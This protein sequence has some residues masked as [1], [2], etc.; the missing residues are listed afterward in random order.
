MSEQERNHL[1]EVGKNLS[2]FIT[3][4]I[5]LQVCGITILSYHFPPKNS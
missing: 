4:D 1:V 3:L 2:R 5:R